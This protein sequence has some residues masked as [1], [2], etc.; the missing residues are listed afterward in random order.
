MECHNLVLGS[1]Y[2]LRHNLA[3]LVVREGVDVDI[4]MVEEFH[5]LLLSIFNGS[6]SLLINRVNSYSTE[7][8]ALGEFGALM[9]INKIGV[10]AYSRLAELD[11]EFMIAIPRSVELNIKIFSNRTHALEW[12]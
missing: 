1:V 2:I 10:V 9:Q 4:D 12:L 5:K 6:F 3:E 7:F 8:N 11:A